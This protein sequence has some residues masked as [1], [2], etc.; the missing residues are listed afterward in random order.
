MA[1]NFGK[2]KFEVFLDDLIAKE[3][4]N[5][6]QLGDTLEKS[7]LSLIDKQIRKKT[8]Q[9]AT[10]TEIAKFM[11][12]FATLSTKTTKILDPAVGCG[13]LL[14]QILLNV[15]NNLIKEIT[16]CDI[17]DIVLKASKLVLMNFDISLTLINCDFLSIKPKKV[18]DVI[19]ANP[20]YIKSNLIKNKE[21]YFE[22]IEKSLATKL[23]GTTGLDAL[24]LLHSLDFLSENGMLIFITP[25]EYLN[26][27]YGE[28][29][30]RILL[31]RY[32]ID[33]LIYFETSDFLFDDGMSSALIT[34]LTNKISTKDH[35][36]RFAKVKKF[37]KATALFSEIC[38][39]DVK[40]PN[41]YKEISVTDLNPQKKWIPLFD[42]DITNITKYNNLVPLSTF[43]SVKR[44]IA[45]GANSFFTLSKEDIDKYHI[46]KKYLKPVLAKANYANPPIFT[47]THFKKLVSINKKCFLL[48][49]KD[50]KPIGVNNYLK[51]GEEQDFHKRYLTRTRKKWFFVEKRRPAKILVKV[52]N[53]G[54][55]IQFILNKTPALNLTCFHG[56]YPKKENHDYLKALI[57]YFRSNIGKNALKLQLRHYGGGLKKLE[58]KDVENLLVPDFSSWNNDV[59]EVLE[60]MFVS[61]SSEDN[62]KN[63][64]GHSN[65]L[66]AII[67]KF[68]R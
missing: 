28:K 49:I 26:S 21:K 24:F 58:P 56:I 14:K 52:F 9:F 5:S 39:E 59:L 8:G 23:D 54:E 10:P 40:P 67:S 6:V 11:A 48:D 55:D 65:E 20:P 13:T 46:P 36:I 51:Y 38:K 60:E 61:W 2:S 32:T 63:D 53:R 33:Y 1:E 57:L 29:L 4:M 42:Q 44:G 16:G 41:Q 7:W 12:L 43:F 35:T 68:V 64:L 25:G 66:N 45:T 3:S 50:E 27:K 19:I 18:Y 37:E 22:I 31:S 17:D 62:G 34:I 15:E 30:K 47:E